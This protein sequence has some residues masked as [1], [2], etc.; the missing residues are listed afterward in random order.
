[1]GKK[2]TN[3]PSD[4]IDVLIP[5]YNAQAYLNEALDSIIKQTHRNW[6]MLIV[7]DGSTDD[8][9]SIIQQYA[10]QDSRI[11]YRSR[12][13]K[14]LVATL[15]ELTAWSTAPFI[16]RMDA[17]D[18]SHEQR[19]EKQLKF[20]MQD[21]HL[22][23]LGSWVQLFGIKNEIWHFRATDQQIRIVSFFGKCSLLHASLM[24]RR[25]VFELYPFDPEFTHLEDFDFLTRIIADNKFKMASMRESLYYYRQHNSSIVYNHEQ[26]RLSKSKQVFK[27]FLNALGLQ[28][29]EYE[30]QLF[31]KFNTGQSVSIEVLDEIGCLLQSIKK[32]LTNNTPDVDKEFD[33]RWLLFCKKNLKSDKIYAYFIKYFDSCDFVFIEL[34]SQYIEA[35][36]VNT[37]S[38]SRAYVSVLGVK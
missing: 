30:L 15:N 11:I 4:L 27:R 12:E 23:L 1:V 16:A 24:C 29:S 33:Y 5:V 31:D 32:V 3:K 6:R 7:D 2:V 21:P 37:S 18:I 17:D 26:L 38:A 34:K 9:L 8:S 19:F 13:N 35:N 14:G 22:S 20:L 10:K 28:L 36:F 25:E